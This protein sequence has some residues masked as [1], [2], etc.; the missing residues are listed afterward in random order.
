MRAHEYAKPVLGEVLAATRRGCTMRLALNDEQKRAL[1][2][3][4]AQLALNVVRHLLGS[5]AA[6]GVSS[7]TFPLTEF[8]FQAVARKLGAEVGIKR[9]RRLIRRLVHAGVLMPAG[10]FRQAYR[11]RGISGF[12]V[13]LYRVLV[14]LALLREK[15]LSAGAGPSRPRGPRRWWEHPLF[16]NPDGLPPPEIRKARLRRMRSADERIPSGWAAA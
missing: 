8:A 1:R 6:C 5:R 10:S 13:A 16:G 15:R 4:D 2:D 12:K 7:G 11:T 9:I 14:L 3:P